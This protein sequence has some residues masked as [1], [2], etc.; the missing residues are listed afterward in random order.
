MLKAKNI[1][2]LFCLNYI[3][4]VIASL[5]IES[6]M[7]SNKATEMQSMIQ[8]AADMALEQ[9][10]V[11]DDF[12]IQ[13]NSYY[14]ETRV[15]EYKVK[16]P[17]DTEGKFK[18][19]NMFK[20]LT[21]ETDKVEIYK[22]MFVADDFNAWLGTA[23]KVKVMAADFSSGGINWYFVPT[24]WQMGYS[25]LNMNLIANGDMHKIK[26]VSG[27]NKIGGDTAALLSPE[28]FAQDYNWLRIERPSGYCLSPIALGVTYINKEYLQ[29]LFINNMDLLMRSQ[30]SGLELGDGI[31]KGSTYSSWVDNTSLAYYNPINNGKF[32]LLRGTRETHNVDGINV[33]TYSGIRQPDIEYKVIDMYDSLND[34]LL[35]TLF[36]STANELKSDARRYLPNGA[37]AADG[38]IVVA[39]V[40]LYANVV[41]PYESLVIR[42]LR[43]M[44]D[45][46]GSI[47]TL[48][49]G[50]ATDAGV[51]RNNG[52][53]NF[54]D[55]NIWNTNDP[56]DY[57]YE[58]TTY[59]AVTP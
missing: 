35:L 38:R 39:K 25:D 7:L 57:C 2:I 44:A 1:I 34:D 28:G 19:V 8:T 4:V 23:S 24:V 37:V 49:L 27:S 20:A 14:G 51:E 58:Y 45:A 55:V 15:N 3:L 36:G 5:F 9:L 17:S 16:M 59:F 26:A 56:S 29:E 11:S 6:A 32:T 30:Y 43:G 42:E 10:Q 52:K 48:E 18:T 12:F 13:D 53:W 46:S 47:D 31:A 40:T 54:L 41:V 50:V 22:K 21:G 33:S